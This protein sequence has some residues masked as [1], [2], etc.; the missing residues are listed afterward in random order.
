MISE[1]RFLGIDQSYT[2]SGYTVLNEVGNIVDFGRI[3][4]TEEDHGDIFDRAWVI[5]KAVGMLYQAHNP[6]FIGIEGLAFSKVGNATRDLAGLQFT[7]VNYLQYIINCPKKKIIIPSPNEIKKF[8][9]GRGN[10]GKNDMIA[11]LPIDVVKLFESR[12]YKKTTG[13]TDIADSYWI[14][15]MILSHYLK[16]FKK[17]VDNDI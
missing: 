3:C 2:S 4:T 9:T 7:I 16:H 13:L 8:A 17:N 1:I 10:A 6:F 5:A 14:S 12:E 15:K 11:T